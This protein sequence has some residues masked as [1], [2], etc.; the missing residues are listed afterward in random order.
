MKDRPGKKTWNEDCAPYV[1]RG[2]KCTLWDVDVP[3]MDREELIAFIGFLDELV[4]DERKGLY[5]EELHKQLRKQL[6][7]DDLI[8]LKEP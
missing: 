7:V 3:D 1:E 4:D 8:H 6:K 2:S 5:W